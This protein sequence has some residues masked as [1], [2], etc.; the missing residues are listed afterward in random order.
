MAFDMDHKS[1]SILSFFYSYKCLLQTLNNLHDSVH[2]DSNISA[3]NNN[4]SNRRRRYGQEN[5]I[6][7]FF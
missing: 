1:N 3:N 5:S 4:W 2:L 6:S 7:I